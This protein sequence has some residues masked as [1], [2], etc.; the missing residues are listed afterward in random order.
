MI[1]Y[2]THKDK[3]LTYQ[4]ISLLDDITL[5]IIKVNQPDVRENVGAKP[6]IRY[7]ECLPRIRQNTK[8]EVG[9]KF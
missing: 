9:P 5:P 2:T 6:N 7:G 3:K 4:I 1:Q 8:I